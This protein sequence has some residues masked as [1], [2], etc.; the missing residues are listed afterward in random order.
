M[1]TT[2]TITLSDAQKKFLSQLA[3]PSR[4]KL[5]LLSQVPM[6][7][8]AGVGLKELNGEQA[9]ISVPYRWLNKN[10]FRSMYFAVMSMAAEISTGTLALLAAHGH[11]PK[12]AGIVTG[13]E[14]SF[15]KKAT[16]LTTFVCQD[17]ELLREAVEK[18]MQTQEPVKVRAKTIG[19]MKDGTEVATFYFEW[20][21]KQK[22]KR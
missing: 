6:A 8:L 12:V 20:S 19:T 1:K 3:N 16:K 22:E 14:A 15:T 18:C 5:F 7:F 13:M 4:F 11:R 17:G 9:R 10:P 2:Q 21:F